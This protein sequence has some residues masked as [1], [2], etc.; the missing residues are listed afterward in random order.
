VRV[1]DGSAVVVVGR[2]AVGFAVVFVVAAQVA[3]VAY[4]GRLVGLEIWDDLGELV[5]G[6]FA[7]RRAVG[8]DNF[9]VVAV[10]VVLSLVAPVSLVAVVVFVAVAALVAALALIANFSVVAV[11]PRVPALVPVLALVSVAS[12]VAVAGLISAVAAVAP[13]GLVPSP[14]LAALVAL[15]AVIA[16]AMPVDIVGFDLMVAL[17]SHLAISEEQLVRVAVALDRMPHHLFRSI[18][19]KAQIVSEAVLPYLQTE[20]LCCSGF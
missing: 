14:A 15:V 9:V 1:G 16:L 5:P 12:H 20:A 4:I 13:I 18:P 8:G 6:R 19:L 7:R 3:A 17:V 2:I 11:A 10:A